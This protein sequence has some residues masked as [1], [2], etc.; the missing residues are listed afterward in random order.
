MGEESHYKVLE[1]FNKVTRPILAEPDW[2]NIIKIVDIINAH[3]QLAPD[4][5]VPKLMEQ[6]KEEKNPKIIWFS[7]IVIDSCVKNCCDEFIRKICNKEFMRR[8]K[9]M[10]YKRYVKKKTAG[11]PTSTYKNLC[12][13]KA[14]HMIQSWGIAFHSNKLRQRYPLF[15]TTYK[16]MVND[17]GVRFPEASKDD[18]PVISH[19]KKS[20][21]NSSGGD[22]LRLSLKKNTTIN[23]KIQELIT[24]VRDNVKLLEDMSKSSN[25]DHQLVEQIIAALKEKQ[26]LINTNVSQNIDN[27]SVT[28][29]LL[30]SFEEIEAV[31]RKFNRSSSNANDDSS[32]SKSTSQDSVTNTNSGFKEF[33]KTDDTFLKKHIEPNKNIG[34]DFFVQDQIKSNNPF[35][36]SPQFNT[37]VYNT[38]SSS[39]SSFFNGS[40]NNQHNGNGS[41]TS[42]SSFFNG[43]G[44]TSSNSSFFNG[45]GNN[46]YNGNGSNQFNPIPTFNIVPSDNINQYQ[47]PN[48]NNQPTYGSN[49]SNMS[50]DQNSSHPNNTQGFNPSSMFTTNQG[51]QVPQLDLFGSS[52]TKLTFSNNDPFENLFSMAKGPNPNGNKT[53]QS[54][55]NNPFG[56]NT[57]TQTQ[58][59]PINNPFM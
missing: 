59:K 31:L 58:N 7:L 42:S 53:V 12:G 22:R 30:Q 23:S 38:G 35:L 37:S 2:E 55:S 25:R 27:E 39:N 29:L 36:D 40:G 46:Q 3:P 44:S 13:E 52:Q 4:I 28:S 11:N 34:I 48:S 5:I 54:D 20:S 17:K 51:Y 47:Q 26:E 18:T 24:N 9:K 19:D 21:K 10:V 56:S 43:N 16:H 1:L 50:F 6:L 49:I 45:S 8:M 15:F 57:Q 14:A 41:T 32:E 33:T